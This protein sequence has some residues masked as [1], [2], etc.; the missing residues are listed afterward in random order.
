V[1][2]STFPSTGGRGPVETIEALAW[3]AAWRLAD[4]LR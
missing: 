4:D 3:R 1:G 2:S